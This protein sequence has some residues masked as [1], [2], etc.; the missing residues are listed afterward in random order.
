MFSFFL[1]LFSMKTNIFTVPSEL[2]SSIANGKFRYEI[3]GLLGMQII[4]LLNPI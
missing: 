2:N 1:Y 4:T 3:R